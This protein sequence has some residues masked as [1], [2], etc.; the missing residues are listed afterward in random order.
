M[1]TPVAV[2]GGVVEA[3]ADQQFGI[4]GAARTRVSEAQRSI[5]DGIAKLIDQIECTGGERAVIGVQRTAGD[6]GN[7]RAGRQTA[8]DRRRCIQV[9]TDVNGGCRLRCDIGTIQLQRSHCT[10][11]ITGAV[12]LEDS[13]L[14]LLAVHDVTITVN[15]ECAGTRVGVNTVV[16]E[17]KEPLP[18]DRQVQVVV[19]KTDITLGKL[20]RNGRHAHTGADGICGH[21]QIGGG[22]DIGKLGA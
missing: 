20:L 13:Q 10:G 12:S 15:A 4:P 5:V 16:V 22:E 6:Q 19:G 18:A 8:G 2:V 17:N 7:I 3:P 9:G 1:L 21:A 14:L 11:D